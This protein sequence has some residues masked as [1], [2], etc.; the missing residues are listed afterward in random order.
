MHTHP[1]AYDLSFDCVCFI[2]YRA[3]QSSSVVLTW[4]N[5]TAV[6]W[7]FMLMIRRKLRWFIEHPKQIVDWLQF[8]YNSLTSSPGTPHAW[9]RIMT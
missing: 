2:F 5:M 8:G 6:Q 7:S 3:I 4:Y 9:P 1:H